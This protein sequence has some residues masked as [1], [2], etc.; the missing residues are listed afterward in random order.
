VLL[1][2]ERFAACYGD[3]AVYCTPEQ[4]AATIDRYRADRALYAEQSRRA[5]AV[6]ARAYHRRGYLT[7]IEA[8]LRAPQPAAPLQ[9]TGP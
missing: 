1:L 3:A 2:P 9:R 8:L 4:A 6:A 5:R 7:R